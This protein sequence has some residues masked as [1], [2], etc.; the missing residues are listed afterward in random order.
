MPHFKTTIREPPLIVVS[1][2]HTK[3]TSTQ[4]TVQVL[5]LL[6]LDLSLELKNQKSYRGK[7]GNR[8]NKG[9]CL[10]TDCNVTGTG[11]DSGT[12]DSDK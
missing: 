1:E 2:L 8:I 10:L 9:D 7:G 6:S 3:L 11:T 12:P 4:Y 5:R